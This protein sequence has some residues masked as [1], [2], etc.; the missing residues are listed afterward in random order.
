MCF[1]RL[2]RCLNRLGKNTKQCSR[3]RV[4]VGTIDPHTRPRGALNR[5]AFLKMGERVMKS[6]FFRKG[7]TIGIVGT[8]ERQ[9]FKTVNLAKKESRKIQL[10]EDGALG[11]GSLVLG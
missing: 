10:R 4:V 9:T 11:R 6:K 5:G 2:G 1:S 3:S 7:K 8:D